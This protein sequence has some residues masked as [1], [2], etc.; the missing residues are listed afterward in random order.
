MERGYRTGF[1]A[2]DGV[3]SQRVDQ[4]KAVHGRSLYANGLEGHEEVGCAIATSN[5]KTSDGM[6]G[7]VAYLVCRYTPPGNMNGEKPF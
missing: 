3:A 2:F 4:R 5:G 7:V 6:A 1:A